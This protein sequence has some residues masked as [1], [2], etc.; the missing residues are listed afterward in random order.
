MAFFV[1]SGSAIFAIKANV[2]YRPEFAL[3][4]HRLSHQALGAA[5]VV[6]YRKRQRL[7]FILK[8]DF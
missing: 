3:Q 1:A 8:Q 6:T 2:E 4:S 7:S 5:V